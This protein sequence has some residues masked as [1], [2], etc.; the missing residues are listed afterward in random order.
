MNL[1]R[2]GHESLAA[3]VRTNQAVIEGE[4]FDTLVAASDS[5]HLAAHITTEVYDALGQKPPQQFIA[6]IYRH[7]DKERTVLFDNSILAPDFEQW[8]NRALGNILLVD[9]EIWRGATL[10]GL[11]DLLHALNA[12]PRSC[13][14]IAEDGGF[15]CPKDIRGVP[16]S[17][18]PTKR[19]V[20]DIYN[21]FSY[22]IPPEFREP[23]AAALRDEPALND[24]QL[25]CTLLG[26]PIK[27]WNNGRPKFTHR[28]INLAMDS[29]SSFDV[30]QKQYK[31]WLKGVVLAYLDQ[32]KRSKQEY[33]EAL[34]C[35]LT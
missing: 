19:R 7:V 30:T 22:T 24:K 20:P 25:M 23:T 17:F 11:F 10:N 27:E 28:L 13:T 12:T 9:D 2:I 32:D 29:L 5:G 34:H 21:A 14:I 31:D 1:N 15:K 4:P 18:H 3:Y 26:L 16:T 33:Q 35:R 6:P 8:R